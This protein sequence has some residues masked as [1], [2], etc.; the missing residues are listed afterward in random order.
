MN[1]GEISFIMNHYAVG[2][3]GGVI[4]YWEIFNPI[5]LN[6][7]ESYVNLLTK[8]RHSRRHDSN[9]IAGHHLRG[10]GLYLNRQMSVVSSWK[11]NIS[12]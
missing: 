7:R 1:H 12:Q 9:S 11:P 2:E 8:W 5:M 4:I 3:P 10:T 6:I